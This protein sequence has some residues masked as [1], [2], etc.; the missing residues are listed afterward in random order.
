MSSIDDLFKVGDSP[1]YQ[2]NTRT[3]RSRNRPRQ[4]ASENSRLHET[5]VGQDLGLVCTLERF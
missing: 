4:A 5:L 3:E 2:E 1:S